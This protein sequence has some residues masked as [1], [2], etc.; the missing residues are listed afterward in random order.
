M[1]EKRGG[2]YN[3]EGLA[4]GVYDRQRNTAKRLIEKYG[5]RVT[6]LKIEN[7]APVDPS[8]PWNTPSIVPAELSVN[9]A[10]FPTDSTVNPFL[11]YMTDKDV[12]TG[13]EI[14]Y[15]ATVDFEPSPQDTVRRSDGT[16]Y[17]IEYIDP[18]RPNGEDTI[19]YT[20]GFK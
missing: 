20:I 19:L 3:S 9:I 18:L 10:F 17:Q 2:S 7:G 8:K 15:M 5:E 14:G 11:H 4:M 16:I 13:S 12:L 6:W 1:L